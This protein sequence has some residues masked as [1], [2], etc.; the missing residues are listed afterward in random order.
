VRH[1]QHA[2]PFVVWCSWCFPRRRLRQWRFAGSYGLG[3]I[4]AMDALILTKDWMTNESLKTLQPASYG[5]QVGRTVDG[6]FDQPLPLRFG[7]NAIVGHRLL[8]S[9]R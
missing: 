4:D 2:D 5:A 6:T 7:V 8:T 1:H 3:S 9:R